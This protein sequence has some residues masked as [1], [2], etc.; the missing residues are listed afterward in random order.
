MTAVPLIWPCSGYES[1]IP[2]RANLFR[3]FASRMTQRGPKSRIHDKT[4]WNSQCQWVIVNKQA[5]PRPV[6]STTALRHALIAFKRV[7]GEKKKPRTIWRPR[8]K[9]QVRN[10]RKVF[11]YVSLGKKYGTSPGGQ[12]DAS[13]D[14]RCVDPGSIHWFRQFFIHGNG[15]TDGRTDIT[16]CT[17]LQLS[18]R[19]VRTH[20]TSPGG[21]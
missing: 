6:L 15:W 11:D 8:L 13:C 2:S 5:G 17:S 19:D 14:G 18:C 16:S 3:F 9:W 1:W 4:K 7:K 21:Q 10:D 20:I 12:I